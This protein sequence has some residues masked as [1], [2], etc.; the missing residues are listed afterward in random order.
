MNSLSEQVRRAVSLE[1]FCFSKPSKGLSDWEGFGVHSE[2]SCILN[3]KMSDS[4]P[5]RARAHP[6]THTQTHTLSIRSLL[7][8]PGSA[9]EWGVVR[10]K[11]GAVLLRWASSYIYK[12][13]GISYLFR[14][15]NHGCFQTPDECTRATGF[16]WRKYRKL[17]SGIPLCQL[18]QKEQSLPGWVI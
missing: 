9:C 5:P 6:H 15:C 10:L 14:F 3:L 11:S 1:A 16:I 2:S 4:P 13:L 17:D 18:L 12:A 8:G 7:S